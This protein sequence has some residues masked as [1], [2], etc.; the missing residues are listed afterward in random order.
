ML[1]YNHINT[2]APVATAFQSVHQNPIATIVAYGRDHLGDSGP[3]DRPEQ[4]VLRDEP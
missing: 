2:A 1:K 3:A 4:G